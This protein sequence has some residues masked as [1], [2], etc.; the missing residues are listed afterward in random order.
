MAPAVRAFFKV[1]P[2]IVKCELC[3]VAIREYRHM[4]TAIPQGGEA[5]FEGLFRD[6]EI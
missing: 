6:L 1:A 2:Q 3:G 4:A 5:D